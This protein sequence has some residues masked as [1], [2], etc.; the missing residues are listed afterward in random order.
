MAGTAIVTGGQ[1]KD[2]APMAVLA[3]NIRDVAPKLADRLVILHDGIS[4]KDRLLINSIFPTE[5]RRFRLYIPWI[6]YRKNPSL[7]YFSNMV[8]CK[9]EC[10]NLLNDYERVIWT[11]YDVVINKD[12]NELKDD[13]RGGLQLIMSEGTLRYKFKPD[14]PEDFLSRYDMVS[15]AG[16]STPL[17]VFTR[18]I[19]DYNEYY[20]WCLKHTRRFAAY[21]NM[22][23]ESIFSL[24]VQE[25]AIPVYPLPKSVYAKQYREGVEDASIYH[26]IAQPKFWNGLYYDKWQAYYEQWLEMGGSEY[27]EPYKEKMIRTVNNV[28]DTIKKR[29]ELSK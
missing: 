11:D 12:L 16:V 22:P 18:A 7:R 10:F 21:L 25:Y 6:S 8:F 14:M 1:K 15:N 20:R 19:G 17:V 27:K 29:I 5:F 24:L 23:E 3:L 28:K 26:A 13:S 2:V 4:R 9:F